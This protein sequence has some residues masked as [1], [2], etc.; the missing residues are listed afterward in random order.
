MNTVSV[1]NIQVV[2][3]QAGHLKD[4]HHVNYNEI[5]E[6]KQT[7][8]SSDKRGFTDNRGSDKQESTVS[9]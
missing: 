8:V 2:E 6:N 4:G 5:H 3:I 1:K 9:S 7:F